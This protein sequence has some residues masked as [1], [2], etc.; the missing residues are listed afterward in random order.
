MKTYS[1]DRESWTTDMDRIL[2]Q[3]MC[4]TGEENKENLIGM[5]YFE[6]D[7]VFCTARQMVDI[8][9]IIDMISDAA[10]E[11]GGEWADGWPDI[12]DK[13]KNELEN[14]IVE[15]LEKKSP[16]TFYHIE[17]VQ[18]KTITEDDISRKF[19]LYQIAESIRK[20]ISR[21]EAFLEIKAYDPEITISYTD[22]CGLRCKVVMGLNNG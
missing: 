13:G 6:G 10:Y 16:C 19:I 8:E 3:L 9:C 1:T 21:D 20:T 15:F 12:T 11:V 14:L 4:S 18:S 2:D 17:N 7:A 22:S 5:E